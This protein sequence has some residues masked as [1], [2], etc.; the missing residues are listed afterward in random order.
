MTVF[1]IGLGG[2]LGA[3]LRYGCVA[4]GARLLGAGFPYGVI[5]ANVA[6]SLAIGVAAALLFE[7]IAAPRA[8][9]FLM[10]GLLGGFTTFSAYSLDAVLM[11]EEG[12]LLAALAYVCGSVI[13]AVAAVALGLQI[14][15]ALA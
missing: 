8:A 1:L 7:K 15:R 9:L 13:L 11:F 14:G 12:R 3:I 5:F 6:G 10:P 2:A 4:A